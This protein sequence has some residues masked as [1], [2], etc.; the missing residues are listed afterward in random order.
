M[1]NKFFL[2]PREELSSSEP[3]D[4][5]RA[6]SPVRTRK[7]VCYDVDQTAFAVT[8]SVIK[9]YKWQGLKLY[10]ASDKAPRLRSAGLNPGSAPLSAAREP[11]R[12]SPALDAVRTQEQAGSS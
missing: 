12:D 10:P 1:E 6:P 5:C 4:L 8:K 7:S 3:C 2:Q 11:E 9:K